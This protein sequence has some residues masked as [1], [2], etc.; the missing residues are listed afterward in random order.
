MSPNHDVRAP[1]YGRTPSGW[2]DDASDR[3]A[4]HDQ[5]QLQ[6]LRYWRS[7]K[8]EPIEREIFSKKY[9]FVRQI[10]WAEFPFTSHASRGRIMG[11]ADIAVRYRAADDS[12]YWLQF[13][14]LKPRIGSVGSLIRQCEAVA[15]LAELA[16]FKHFEVLPAVYSDDPKAIIFEE[17]HGRLVFLPRPG[18]EGEP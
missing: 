4:G 11:F 18:A 9:T 15:N 1:V 5:M 6:M 16:G 7:D 2:H 8:L 10:V 12:L 3:D 13:Y 17:M 14:E